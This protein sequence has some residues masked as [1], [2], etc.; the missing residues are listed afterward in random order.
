MLLRWGRQMGLS[1]SAAFEAL[2]DVYCKLIEHLP[3]FI[4]DPKRSFRGWLHRVLQNAV[5]D[6]RRKQIRRPLSFSS[7]LLQAAAA[8]SCEEVETE[9]SEAFSQLVE[10]AQAWVL[11][12]QSRVSEKTWKAF[13]RTAIDG[14]DARDVA[15]EL[16]MSMSSVY[17]ARNRVRNA[18]QELASRD[19]V[20]L[21]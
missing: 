3:T 14:A 16:N 11:I 4:Y 17:V 13:S 6:Q 15:A 9:F 19:S 10:Q 1:E 7:D 8:L 20:T 5:M 12:V 18:L 2:S 21:G